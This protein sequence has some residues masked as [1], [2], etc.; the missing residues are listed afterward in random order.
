MRESRR[1]LSQWNT[2]SGKKIISTISLQ[3]IKA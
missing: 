2:S 1:L 3:N